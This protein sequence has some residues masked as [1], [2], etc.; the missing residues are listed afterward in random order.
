MS[1]PARDKLIAALELLEALR[2][3]AQNGRPEDRPNI[4]AAFQKA[5]AEAEKAAR[6]WIES[7]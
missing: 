3:P 2:M 7:C 5:R 4:N 1:S 6:E